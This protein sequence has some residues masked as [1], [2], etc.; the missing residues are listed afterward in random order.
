VLMQVSLRMIRPFCVEWYAAT[1][2]RHLSP[3]N[4]LFFSYVS[5]FPGKNSFL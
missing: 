2:K 4:F 3:L 5:T 1:T